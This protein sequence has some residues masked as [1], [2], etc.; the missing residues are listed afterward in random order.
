MNSCKGMQGKQIV[1]I[2]IWLVCIGK[3]GAHYTGDFPSFSVWRAWQCLTACLNMNKK[4]CIILISCTSYKPLWPQIQTFKHGSKL[5]FIRLRRHEIAFI[6]NPPS[7]WTAQLPWY[8]QCLNAALHQAHSTW[9]IVVMD[10]P[11]W[12]SLCLIL[13]S[14]QCTPAL[15]SSLVAW[16]LWVWGHA[17]VVNSSPCVGPLAPSSLSCID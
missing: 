10:W 13:H 16:V 4:C 9:C 11:Q 2:C 17:Q 14:I 3:V 12:A 5:G 6:F 1:Y 8:H 7:L 15:H